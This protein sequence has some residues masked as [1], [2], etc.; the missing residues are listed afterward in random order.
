M[1]EDL[2]REFAGE[3]PSV[4]HEDLARTIRDVGQWYWSDPERHRSG[5]LDLFGTRRILVGMALRKLGIWD[6]ALVN[7]LADEFSHRRETSAQ[8]FPETV[9]VLT[10]L[11]ER[12]FQLAM[13]TNGAGDMQRAKLDRF[14][15]EP[16]F[17]CIIIEGEFG[18]GKPEPDGFRYILHTLSAT[19]AEAWMVGNDL[20]HDI[21]PCGPL[22]IFS[23]WVD[24][25]GNGVPANSPVKPDR[26]IKDIAELPGLLEQA[27]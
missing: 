21:A 16:Y 14:A 19:A 20:Q 27:R 7:R 5:R 23:V 15:L 4:P 3:F 9:S 13:I 12:G 25:A 6:E 11:R 2:C 17:D 26:V 1:W 18:V 8:I 22:G 10:L 24:T